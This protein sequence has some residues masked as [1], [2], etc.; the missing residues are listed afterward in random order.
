MS[1]REKK[2]LVITLIVALGAG[3]FLFLDSS[4]TQVPASIPDPAPSELPA[5][6]QSFETQKFPELQEK[7]VAIEL[8]QSQKKIL[9][10][11]SI[12]WQK[13]IFYKDPSRKQGKTRSQ[14]KVETKLFSYT[15]FIHLGDE[16]FAII[17]NR[18]YKEGD[19]LEGWTGYSVGKITRENVIIYTPQKNPLVVSYTD[20]QPFV[21]KKPEKKKQ[22]QKKK[23]QH[24]ETQNK[25]K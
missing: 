15:G 14:K 21:W 18:N 10:Q 23:P 20:I 1:S 22:K 25:K 24:V 12:P 4:S 8:S 2:L 17:N 3:I 13:D 19:S 11:S 16:F 6:A 7:T 5:A 9:T